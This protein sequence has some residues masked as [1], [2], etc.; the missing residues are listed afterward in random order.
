M[1]LTIHGHFY[2]P[3]R[4]N[5]WTGEIPLQEGAAP[6]HDWNEK[7]A[8]QCYG[9][10][11][12]SRVLDPHGRIRALVNNYAH[13]SFDFGPTLLSDLE[14]RFP[15]IYRRIQEADRDSVIRHGG[16]G[17]AIA[18]GY[19]H[20]ILPL[21]NYRDKWTQVRWGLRDFEHRFARR[22][23]GL[24]LPETA[25]DEE[26]LQVVTQAG[27]R[28]LILA[29]NQARRWRRLGE[30]AWKD[31]SAGQPIDTR[32]P[33]RCAVNVPGQRGQAITVFF[34]D[35]GLAS[36]VSFEHLLRD[37]H[38]FSARLEEAGRGLGQEM[39]VHL[40]TDGEIYGHHEPFAD[41]CLSSF[42]HDLA[43]ERRMRLMNY[44]EFLSA[45]PP[46][47]EV[48]LE[49]TETGEG[50]AWSCVHGIGRW[51][52][53]CG[54][55]TG[56][57][58]GWSQRW[59]TPLRRGLDAVRD[60]IQNAWLVRTSPI[61]KDPWAARDDY[62]SVLLSPDEETREAFLARHLR[63]SIDAETRT[64]LW[65]LLE[66]CHQAMLMYTSC[67]WFFADISGIEVQQNLCY[68]ARACELAQPFVAEPLQPLLLR[69][70]EQA[71]SNLPEWGNGANVFRKA[72]LP[73]RFGPE[74]AATQA[75]FET[76]DLE[77]PLTRRLFRF[78]L[79][80]GSSGPAA[81]AQT[82]EEVISADRV[83]SGAVSSDPI[84]WDTAPAA[85]DRTGSGRAEPAEAGA[86]SVARGSIQVTDRMTGQRW[87]WSYAVTGE[88][89]TAQSVRLSPGD[90]TYHLRDLSPEVREKIALHALSRG[91][92]EQGERLQEIFRTARAPMRALNDLGVP[93]P[94]VHRHLAAFCLDHRL[95]TLAARI[96]AVTPLLAIE[97]GPVSEP[98]REGTSE[99][100]TMPVRTPPGRPSDL[101]EDWWEDVSAVLQDSELLSI[102][103]E[104]AVVGVPLASWINAVLDA[105]MVEGDPAHALQSVQLA[106]ATL[107]RADRLRLPLP[108][109]G[110]E[111][112]VYEL[113]RRFRHEL[114]ELLSES[115]LER[116]QT[117]E[118]VPA[119]RELAG[120]ANLELCAILREFSMRGE[121]PVTSQAG[122][123]HPNAQ[124]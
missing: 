83:L 36:A 109:T 75:V 117:A 68:A 118:G 93:A 82:E 31:V 20:M 1:N 38:D 96:P 99:P 39:L 76:V 112:R 101:A 121:S 4:E 6:A 122:G 27:I 41:M 60:Q 15:D 71:R 66:A 103:I 59:R 86:G 21:A 28:Y 113:V 30:H 65:M 87:R 77:R 49:F 18:Q 100:S 92:D 119:L 5:P 35:P 51:T 70:L 12:S 124:G 90:V 3:P 58:P 22:S 17:N 57:Q 62:I 94:P 42:I 69:Y 111:V 104:A 34:Y 115:A 8:E 44:G 64:H 116:N 108:R 48:E 25:A 46:Q 47:D 23:E 85:P 29:P 73:R 123:S 55:S 105:A 79:A 50:T 45:C 91:L 54:C 53:D 14:R 106:Y 80:S 74:M 37:A 81:I 33:Y 89:P 67:A 95:R 63:S 97:A 10:N 13:I 88:P 110:L 98:A 78:D 61:L 114:E 2:Q 26:T 40:A 32:R 52:R 9:P 11:A 24:W 19:N 16:H 102:G 120:H 7:I 72:V 56:G 43:P 107:A 84:V